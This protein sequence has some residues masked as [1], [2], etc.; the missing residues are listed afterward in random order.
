MKWISVVIL[1]CFFCVTGANASERDSKTIQISVNLLAISEE[2]RAMRIQLCKRAKFRDYPVCEDLAVQSSLSTSAR[3]IS[4]SA[5]YSSTSG[6][7]PE[8]G[9]Q[10]IGDLKS[11]SEIAVVAS[12]LTFNDQLSGNLAPKQVEFLATLLGLELDDALGLVQTND[13][14]VD[15]IAANTWVTISGK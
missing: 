10:L 7:L 4:S 5:D 3:I 13:L 2:G 11:Q 1:A 9:S 15:E 6:V 12:M 8:V 14:F